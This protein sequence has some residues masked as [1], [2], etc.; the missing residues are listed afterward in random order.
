MWRAE[1]LRTDPDSD[2]PRDSLDP[3]LTDH[4]ALTASIRAGSRGFEA[5]LDEV[6]VG[7]ALMRTER[8]GGAVLDRAGRL[9]HASPRFTDIDGLNQ[10]DADIVEEVAAHRR[11]RTSFTQADDGTGRVA[12]AY[13]PP[14]QARG[15]TLP[16]DVREAIDRPEAAVVVLTV[17]TVTVDAAVEDACRAFG[18]TDLQTRVATGLV[19]TGDARGAGRV[20]GVTYETAR[21]TLADAM[22][23]VGAA[24]LSGLIERLVRLSFGVWPVG[25]GGEAVLTDVWG[26]TPRQAIL[27]LRVSEGLTRAEAARAAGVSEA[28]TKKDLDVV[29]ATLGVSTSAALARVVTEARA[30]ALLTDATHGSV[31]AADDFIEP[32]NLFLRPDGSQV[33]Y[34]DY[35]PRSGQPVLVLHSSSSCRPVPS[36]LV[37]ALQA[38]GLRPLALD[39]PGFGLSD[40]PSDRAGWRADPFATAVDDIRLLC[41]HLKLERV[42]VVARGGAQ[43]AVAMHVQARELMRRVVLVNPDPTTDDHAPGHGPTAA[44]KAAFVRHPDLIEKL[45]ATLAGWLGAGQ[46]RRMIERVVEGSPPDIAVMADPRNLSDYMRGFRLFATGRVAGYVAEQTAMTRWTSPPLAGV[47]GWRVLVGAHDRMHQPS[48]VQAF[49]REVLPGA[50][51]ELVEDGGRYLAFSHAELVAETLVAAPDVPGPS[52]K[53]AGQTPQTGMGA[54]EDAD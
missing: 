20:A 32:L 29:F 38:V 41:R 42:D 34:S 11:S 14:D 15:W 44:V 28:V 7:Y 51:Q 12:I 5:G 1:S 9:I 46:G 21:K 36:R 17:A 23:R 25:R 39:R 4:E 45:A 16:P 43:V 27:A 8:L 35:G 53:R 26:L 52:P 10:L 33:A 13:G 48:H 24:R 47:S 49:W 3:W 6:A 37:H 19:R 22:R 30:M 18:L 40:P 2:L 54:P 31:E 50:A